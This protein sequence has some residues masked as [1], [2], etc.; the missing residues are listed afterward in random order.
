M[1]N[2]VI[3]M[4]KKEFIEIK[5]SGLIR[6]LVFAPILQV[7]IFGYV[8]T[9]DIKHVSTIV[10]D[11][12]VTAHSR[13]LTGKF[14]NTRYFDVN[15]Y[16]NGPGEIQKTLD[17]NKAAVCLRIPA[18]FSSAI[19]SGER[20][21]VQLIVDGSDS[22]KSLISLNRAALIIN[23]FSKNVFA[24]KMEKMKNLTG[25]LPSARMEERVWYN[26]EL[27]S[28]NTMVPGVIALI[29]MIVTL[30]VSALAIVREKET[31]NIEQVM[32]APIKPAEII[33]GKVAPYII[34]GLLDI[35]LITVMGVIV[36]HIPFEGSFLL[37]LALSLFMI[38]TNLGLGIYISTIS[39]TQQQAMLSAMFFA[40]PSILL[41]GFVFPI[42]NMPI[43]LQW[44]TYAI[45]MRYFITIIRGI[46]LKGL[47][48][49]ELLPQTIALFV[50]GVIIFTLA[51]K[52]FKKII[53]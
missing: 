28:A 52:K 51:I 6:L 5:R 44:F 31:G 12:D 32:V 37:L 24:Q 3:S 18:G 23:G 11:E 19:K 50:F 17:T 33:M 10:C 1:N 35:A 48:F 39:S 36:F 25:P 14:V 8:A 4:M 45:P 41:S 40:F 30:I 22:N 29:L 20:V 42:N 13:A 38:L 27:K 46:F 26:P 43:V 21:K 47:G 7:I 49:Y 2:P 53:N 9:T 16:T 34:I 15:Y